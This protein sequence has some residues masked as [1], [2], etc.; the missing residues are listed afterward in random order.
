MEQN[1]LSVP[2]EFATVQLLP[3]GSAS[4]TNS[5]GEFYFDRLSPGRINLRIEFLGMEPID[6]TFTL[7]AGRHQELTFQMQEST[8]R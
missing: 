3:Q 7:T 5:K 4:T 2:V 1:N 8:F 6:T